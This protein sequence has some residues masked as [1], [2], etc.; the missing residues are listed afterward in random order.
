MSPDTFADDR[1][2]RD[3]DR[4]ATLALVVIL[5]TVLLACGA[6]VIDLGFLY[7]ERRQL[8]NGADA[9]A[10]AVAQDCAKGNCLDE[11]GTARTAASANA[12]S[13]GF[14]AVDV[15]CG[16]GPQAAQVGLA[17]CIGPTPPGTTNALGWVK[18]TTSTLDGAGGTQ[19][20][21][22]LD[23][24][25]G[26]LSGKTVHATA[27]A[28]WGIA[29]RGRALPFVMADCTF[30][31]LGG[32]ILNGVVPTGNVYI[33]SEVLSSGGPDS[34]SGRETCINQTNGLT[35]PG[36]FG[37]LESQGQCLLDLGLADPAP[38]DPG[39]DSQLRRHC[40][41]GAEVNDQTVLLAIY[42]NYVGNGAN[43]E[44]TLVGFVGFHVLGYRLSGQSWPRGFTCPPNPYGTNSSGGNDR[45]FY[46]YF[47]EVVSDGDFGGSYNLGVRTVKMIG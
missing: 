30:T 24:F 7:V 43:A 40:G 34:F 29:A 26:A 47:T 38:S 45:C 35:M 17:A 33:Y 8:Q 5:L 13:D 39:N 6:I 3:R 11:W 22:L 37:W 44:Y 19:I 27:I 9:A 1:L 15:V 16:G 31:D 36:A 18:V 20:D 14:S 28:A 41:D 21:F 25:V 42:N 10:L 12:S 2:D 46:G 32:D 23:A 4:G